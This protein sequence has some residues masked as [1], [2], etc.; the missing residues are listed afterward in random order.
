MATVLDSLVLEFNLD[1]SQFTREQQRIL[2]QI[3][4]MQEEVKTRAIKAQSPS[5][6]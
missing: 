3:R 5:L 2:D 1:P 4:K 6:R